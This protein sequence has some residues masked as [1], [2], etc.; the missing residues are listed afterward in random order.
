MENVNDLKMKPRFLSMLDKPIV[1]IVLVTMLFL[2]AG[3]WYLADM[4]HRAPTLSGYDWGAHPKS[5][6]IVVPPDEC[7]CGT[8]PKQLAREALQRGFHVVVA[9][10][11]MNTPVQRVK[12][13]ATG[14]KLISLVVVPPPLVAQFASDKKT[15]LVQVTRGRIV[16]RSSGTVTMDIFNA[17]SS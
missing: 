1:T 10:S 14:N 16:F 9:Y 3:S 11:T 5:L 17:L 2:L 7:G 4:G 13:L 15:Q 12:E 8:T 6:M